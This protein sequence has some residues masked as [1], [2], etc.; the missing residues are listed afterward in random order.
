MV[1]RQTAGEGGL[2]RPRARQDKGKG[3]QTTMDY[4]IDYST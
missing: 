3:V 2:K 1:S 4:E